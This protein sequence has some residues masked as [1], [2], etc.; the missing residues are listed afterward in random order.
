[1]P[2]PDDAA[3]ERPE[4]RESRD[5]WEDRTDPGTATPDR[6][7]GRAGR[8]AK[9]TR[10]T[11]DTRETREAQDTQGGEEASGRQTGV[12]GQVGAGGVDQGPADQ[13]DRREPAESESSE[14]GAPASG[15]PERRDT[16]ASSGPADHGVGARGQDDRPGRRGPRESRGWRARQDRRYWHDWDARPGHGVSIGGFA[17]ADGPGEAGRFG[18]SGGFDGPGAA[19][20]SDEHLQDPALARALRDLDL[21]GPVVPAWSPAEVRA[22]G[23]RRRTRRRA[24]WSGSGLVAAALVGALIAGPLTPG[25]GS[26]GA[27]A[28][29]EAA[30]TAP[31]RTPSAGSGAATAPPSTG[32]P[33]LPR[34]AATLDIDRQVLIAHYGNGAADQEIPGVV[35]VE[36][37]KALNQVTTL[38]VVAKEAKQIVPSDIAG[39]EGDYSVLVAWAVALELPDK[40]LVYVGSPTTCTDY[41]CAQTRLGAALVGFFTEAWAKVFFDAVRVDDTVNVLPP[42]PVRAGTARPETVAPSRPSIVN[43]APATTVKPTGDPTSTAEPSATATTSP[44]A[45]KTP[46][47]TGSKTDLPSSPTPTGTSSPT[48]AAT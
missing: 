36:A 2:T 5:A 20:S 1:M 18:A 45:T 23:N 8:D 22:R 33:T 27:T 25:R 17:D 7:S 11:Q 39:P 29:G 6:R 47:P 44:T 3:R 19:G 43:P 13:N 48:G 38:R 31:A 15:V 24:A 40:S 37:V 30:S 28:Q 16:Q 32:A 46:T 14:G 41:S 12:A 34:A 35:N 10:D 9:D 21:P 42:S 26:G 4:D